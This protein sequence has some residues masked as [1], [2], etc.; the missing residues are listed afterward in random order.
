MTP[1]RPAPGLRRPR[2]HAWLPVVAALAAPGACNQLL[3]NEDGRVASEGGG[4]G[5]AGAAGAAVALGGPGA[6]GGG[7]GAADACATIY[8]SPAGDD[9]NEGCAPAAPK[10]S[11]AAAL[12]GAAAAPGGARRE[13]RACRGRYD[14]AG[15]T[16]EA[17][18]AL[19]GGYDCAGFRRGAGF[20]LVGNFLSKDETTIASADAGSAAPALTLRGAAVRPETV[21]VEGFRVVGPDAGEG[22]SVAVLVTEGAA[23][24]LRDNLIEGGAGVDA[25]FGSAGLWVSGGAAPEVE[26]NRIDGGRGACA[27]PGGTGSAGVVLAREA[28]AA[29]LRRNDVSGG[30]G[31]CDAGA[32]SV[33]V[34]VLTGAALTGGRAIEGNAIG[35][36]AGRVGRGAA[37]TAVELRGDAATGI[38][39]EAELRGNDLRGGEGR[40]LPGG[41]AAG[42]GQLE[43]AGLRAYDARRVA[44][45]RNRIYA[46]DL[47]P[48]GSA[49]PTWAA[50]VDAFG[51]DELSLENNMVLGGNAAGPAGLDATRAVAVGRFGPA[52]LVR[53]RH[54]TLVSGRPADRAEGAPLQAVALDLA[55]VTGELDVRNNALVSV[56]YGGSAG[57]RLEAC[58]GGFES[59]AFEN[60][61]LFSSGEGLLRAVSPAGCA[62]PGGAVARDLPGLA[63]ALARFDVAHTSVAGNRRVSTDRVC[64]PSEL[65]TCHAPA[66][67]Q[68]HKPCAGQIFAGLEDADGGRGAFEAE[69]AF[70]L[71][72]DAYCGVARGAALGPDGLPL[73]ADDFAGRART[74]PEV[75]IGAHEQDGEGC[76]AAAAA[77]PSARTF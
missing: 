26:S 70:A 40:G 33:G 34:A 56:W 73:A 17:P 31:R 50:G 51:V 62:A 75:S 12:A 60:N 21:E 68:G 28:G 22:P 13:V 25:A 46:G 63:E 14:E 58:R 39:V 18:V 61:L 59:L 6:T 47:D 11:L 38:Y 65:V 7:A 71:R 52:R 37:A 66:A 15:L 16:V 77:P 4:A 74:G 9:A 29:A 24:T 41:A 35:G 76:A 48:A 42:G 30:E 49:L 53:L 54:N 57:A 36:G 67:C 5:A 69:A 27:G 20:G 1:P 8:V 55:R 2:A 32:G 43:V 10:R 3:G 72:P 44:L 23:P 64:G 19:R 45:A